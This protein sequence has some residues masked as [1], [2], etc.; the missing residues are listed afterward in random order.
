MNKS[1]EQLR[2]K[3]DAI[4][5]QIASLLKSR[6]ALAKAIGELKKNTNSPILDALREQEVLLNASNA[7]LNEDEKVAI[8]NIYKTIITECK[9]LQK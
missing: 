8:I 7:V 2:N 6:F 4:D 9:N 5:E 3:I 1:K